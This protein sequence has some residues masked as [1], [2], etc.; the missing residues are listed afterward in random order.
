[1]QSP[2]FVLGMVGAIGFACSSIFSVIF[3]FAI[4][5]E[6]QKTNEIS[7][8]MITG[9]VGGALFPP[10]MTL[11]TQL[12]NGAQMGGLLVLSFAAIYLLFLSF[13]Q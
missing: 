6:P 9:V 7:G 4:Q 1:V 11:S 8:L 2:V 12:F 10:L 5:S 3:S 13:N